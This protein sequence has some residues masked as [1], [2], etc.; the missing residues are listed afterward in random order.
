MSELAKRKLRGVTVAPVFKDG[1]VGHVPFDT[2]HHEMDDNIAF[3]YAAFLHH[4]IG[5][6]VG[7]IIQIFPG[8]RSCAGSLEG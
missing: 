7:L 8:N 1:H 6:F 2:V 3:L 5:E 4:K